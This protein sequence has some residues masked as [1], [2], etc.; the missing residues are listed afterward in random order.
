[1]ESLIQEV[2][3]KNKHK[4]T[5]TFILFPENISVQFSVHLLSLV[6]WCQTENLQ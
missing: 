1:M 3:Y 4:L 6:S 2:T 5:K